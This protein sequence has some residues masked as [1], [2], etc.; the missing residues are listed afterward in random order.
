MARIKETVFQQHYYQCLR[1][2]SYEL[3][4]PQTL[5]ICFGFSFADEHIR[6][7][8]KRSLSNKQ[9][10]VYIFCLS[11]ET[12]V[13]E[14]LINFENIKIIKPPSDEEKINFTKFIS[15][16]FNSNEENKL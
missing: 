11:I 12:K 14:D 2:L 3:E 1:L 16:L 4:K 10:I 15:Y 6:E 9:L 7:I 8:V 5:L 13:P